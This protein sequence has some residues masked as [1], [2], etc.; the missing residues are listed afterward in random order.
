M[1][2]VKEALL[3]P[4]V[5]E[6]GHPKT[7]APTEPREARPPQGADDAQPRH[8]LSPKWHKPP[9]PP[10]SCSGSTNGTCKA[11]AVPPL[12]LPRCLAGM[13]GIHF[14]W[15]CPSLL[16]APSPPAFSWDGSARSTKPGHLP[17]FKGCDSSRAPM[18]Y[19]KNI[20]SC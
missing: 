7:A 3:F 2:V 9:S 20:Q 6:N 13:L 1:L 4:L 19:W 17:I 11:G 18:P 5:M 15:Q 14:W 8:M 16:W 10:R 12:S